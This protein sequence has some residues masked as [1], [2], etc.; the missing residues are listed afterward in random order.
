MKIT[1]RAALKEVKKNGLAKILPGK[2]RITVSAGTCGI[3][4]GATEVHQEFAALIKKHGIAAYLSDVGCFGFCVWEPLVTIAFPGKPLVFLESVTRK[5][6]PGIVEDIV[7]GRIPATKVLGKAEVWEHITEKITYGH[8]LPE[9]PFWYEVPFFKGQE[10]IVLRNCGLIN[11]EDIEEYIAVGGYS[12]LEKTLDML[13]PEQVIEEVSKSKLRGRGGAGFPT[14]KKWEFLKLKKA[15][16]KYIICNADEGDPG[17]FM[18]R[19]EIESDPHSVVEGM[20]IGAYAIGAQEG[21]VYMRAEYPL[22]VRR[23]RK[24]IQQAQEYGLLG[25]DIMGLKFDFDI[26]IVEGAGAFVC[27]E[28]TALIESIEGKAGRPR[29]RPPYPADRGLWGKPTNINNVETWCNIPVIISKGGE[30]FA[31]IGTALSTG[32]KVFSLVGKVKNTGL[33]ELPLGTPI[34]TIVYNIGEA[35]SSGKKVKAVLTGGPSGGCIPA[36]HFNATVD[37]ESLAALGAI[38][39]S[40]GMV[41]MNEDSCMVDVARYFTEFSNSESCGKCVPC[42]EGLYHILKKMEL[43]TRGEAVAEDLDVLLQLGN[44]IKDSAF[45]ALGQTAPNPLLTTLKYF[46]DEYEAHVKDKRCPARVCPELTYY[47][48]T[49]ELC[50]GCTKCAKACPSSAINGGAGLVHI[51]DLGKCIKCGACENVCPFA[52]VKRISAQQVQPLGK[53]IPV[54]KKSFPEKNG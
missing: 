11:P 41:V 17:A 27:G 44:S 6:V 4:N 21:I 18:N 52:S 35:G 31:K 45:C 14:G 3:G 40:G 16:H 5:D 48:I 23:M 33:V 42:R 50:K 32:T 24:A 47:Y 30:W 28:E 37:Y 39:G 19:N 46:K 20:I 54:M 7:A 38:M 8:G 13:T 1:T 25:Q 53:P 2:V 43:I 26:S 34:Q 15:E 29:M 9:V 49:P 12:A 10:K 22:A 36:E 51:I